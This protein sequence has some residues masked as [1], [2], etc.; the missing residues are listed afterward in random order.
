MPEPKHCAQEDAVDFPR[1]LAPRFGVQ[2]LD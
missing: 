2:L 1:A